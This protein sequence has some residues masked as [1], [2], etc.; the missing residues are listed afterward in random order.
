MRQHPVTP[1]LSPDVDA[2]LP[3]PIRNAARVEGWGKRV[4]R[5]GPTQ[6]V[7]VAPGAATWHLWGCDM[8]SELDYFTTTRRNVLLVGG[9]AAAGGAIVFFAAP[10]LD[11]GEI[12]VAVGVGAVGHLAL[13]W[14]HHRPRTVATITIASTVLTAF[15]APAVWAMIFLLGLRFTAKTACLYMAAAVVPSAILLTSSVWRWDS[16]HAL[17]LATAIVILSM[18]MTVGAGGTGI[19]LGLQRRR[20]A[21]ITDLFLSSIRRELEASERATRAERDRVA[22][23]LHDDLGHSL[24]LINLYVSGMETSHL[25]DGEIREAV[26]TIRDQNRAA[27]VALATAISGLTNPTSITPFTTRFWN[28]IREVRRAGL[29]VAVEVAPDAAFSPKIAE[30]ALRVIQEGLT[31][32][33]RYADPPQARVRVKA[34]KEG[35]HATVSVES[36]YAAHGRDSDL[37]SNGSGIHRLQSDAETLRSSVHFSTA[38]GVATLS[39][40]VPTLT[41]DARHEEA[42]ARTISGS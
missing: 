40:T 16:S 37:A 10:A 41:P 7:F 39:C 8:Q 42:P 2:C 18:F 13:L 11:S 22:R 35:T 25:T 15:S 34:G 30:F 3:P 32:A 14:N 1:G 24:A 31:N 29:A 19:A 6:E 5:N 20:N 17:G 21:A 28:I 27:S 12:A 33:I 4:A 26:L 38:R 23:I 36:R 9:S